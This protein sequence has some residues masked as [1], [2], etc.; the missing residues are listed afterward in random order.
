M[1]VGFLKPKFRNQY[2]IRVRLEVGIIERV[3]LVLEARLIMPITQARPGFP[4]LLV[5]RYP[6]DTVAGLHVPPKF[7]DVSLKK[8]GFQLESATNFPPIHAQNKVISK[9][10]ENLHF[11]T[12]TNFPHSNPKSR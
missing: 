2:F 10:K 6:L 9:K 5:Y 4:K 8:K 7:C 12:A 3:E 11:S 1:F